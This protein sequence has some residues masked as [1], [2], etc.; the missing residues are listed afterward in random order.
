MEP[1]SSFQNPDQNQSTAPTFPPIS[2]FTPP[3]IS[4]RPHRRKFLPVLIAIVLLVFVAAGVFA[5][6]VIFEAPRA[7]LTKSLAA[8]TGA[9]A[10]HQ[11]VAIK[12]ALESPTNLTAEGTVATDVVQSSAVS[13]LSRVAIAVNGKSGGFSVNV[14]ARFIDDTLYGKVNEFPFLPLIA[15][16]ATDSPVGK[17]Y[18]VSLGDLE[19]YAAEQ[20]VSPESI[21]KV[22]AQLSQSQFGKFD[23]I[24][25]SDILIQSGVIVPGGRA[26]IL[27]VDGAWSRQY[28]VTVNKDRLTEFIANKEKEFS[29]NVPMAG[30][31]DSQSVVDSLKSATF[32]PVIVTIGLFDHSLKKIAGGVKVSANRPANS[33]LPATKGSLSFVIT[34]RDINGPI[35][36]A[37]PNNAISL[38]E[39]VKKAMQEAKNKSMATAIK[40]RLSSV[41]AVAEIYYDK[42]KSYTNLCIKDS[43]VTA[44]LKSIE[45]ESDQKPTCRSNSKTFLSASAFASSSL[46]AWCVDSTGFSGGV[47]KIPA[48]FVCE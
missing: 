11:D 26:S 4:T 19:G 45:E 36:V 12:V 40:S 42:K 9:R 6:T 41:R 21:A 30:V 10:V 48:G 18:S 46:A 31:A 25:Q 5:Y 35:T 17:W 38:M 34:Y 29:A 8:I 15:S 1:S 16:Y 23:S 39:Y 3:P 37:K 27:R 33:M 13:G 44:I 47:D 43:T 7:A 14:E 20:G 32:D 2:N 24:A 28:T 22:K